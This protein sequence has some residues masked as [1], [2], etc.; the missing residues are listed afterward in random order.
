[1]SQN[2]DKSNEDSN[3]NNHIPNYEKLKK[4]RNIFSSP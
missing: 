3:L 2:T 4:S 1:M